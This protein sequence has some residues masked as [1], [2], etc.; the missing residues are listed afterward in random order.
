MAITQF[1]PLN[2]SGSE[3]FVSQTWKWLRERFGYLPQV[4]LVF[5]EK[6]SQLANAVENFVDL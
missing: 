3:V 2:R 1:S 6:L 5:G 4:R